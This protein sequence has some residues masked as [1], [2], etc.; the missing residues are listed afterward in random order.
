[1]NT[2][3]LVP[4]G[5]RMKFCPSEIILLEGDINYTILHFADGSKI[6]TSTNIGKLE[7]RFACFNFFRTNRSYMINLDFISKY[8]KET[9]SIRMENN[10]MIQLSRR[11][12]KQF[13]NIT[14]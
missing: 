13:I 3:N 9:G 5:G 7:P 2:K 6:L 10:E 14:K 4:V 1:M 8:E 12:T 11:R